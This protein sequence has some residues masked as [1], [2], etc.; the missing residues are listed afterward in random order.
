MEL[1]CDER[2]IDNLDTIAR[3]QYGDTLVHLAVQPK[4]LRCPVAFGNHSIKQRIRHVLQYKNIAAGLAAV[5]LMLVVLMMAALGVD[6]VSTQVQ[7]EQLADQ[8]AQTFADRDG[9]GRYDL[10][11]SNLQQQ[12]DRASAT[13]TSQW[14][15]PVWVTARTKKKGCFCG[16]P[17]PGWKA[18]S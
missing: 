3:C 17:A 15:M 4:R 12:V 13:D 18:G 9:T 14:W 5:A 11:T 7:L 2:A 8:W 10:M 6:P 1:A 16:A